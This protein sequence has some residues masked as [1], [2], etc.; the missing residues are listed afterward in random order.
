MPT[1]QWNEDAQ[2]QEAVSPHRSQ[3]SDMSESGTQRKGDTKRGRRGERKG[4]EAKEA[5]SP[6]HKDRANERE[7]AGGEISH[8]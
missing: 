8:S 7:R 3:L 4:H 1:G 5:V 2:S 6:S